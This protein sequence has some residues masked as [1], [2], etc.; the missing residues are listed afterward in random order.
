ME[1]AKKS[2]GPR[3]QDRVGMAEVQIMNLVVIRDFCAEWGG[4]LVK[5]KSLSWL[6][7][8]LIVSREVVSR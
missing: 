4:E 1:G 6:A 8:D 5:A 3:T 7:F 2:S